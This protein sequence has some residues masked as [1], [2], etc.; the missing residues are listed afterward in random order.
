MNPEP[1]D[2]KRIKPHLSLM[3]GKRDRRSCTS[4]S[5]SSSPSTTVSDSLQAVRA[6]CWWN[7][8]SQSQMLHHVQVR[9]DYSVKHLMG[10]R[11]E[12]EKEPSKSPTVINDIAYLMLSPL[13]VQGLFYPNSKLF[14]NLVSCLGACRRH[15]NHDG[16]SKN[17]QKLQ[18]TPHIR[19][20]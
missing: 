4:T 20:F 19:Q 16:T 2:V 6:S 8:I 14:Q 17:R 13:L 18:S 12:W 3:E 7:C 1:Q 15:P 10:S 9:P 11:L 5:S